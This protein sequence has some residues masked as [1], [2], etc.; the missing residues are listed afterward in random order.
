MISLTITQ[1]DLKKEITAEY[2]AS[3]FILQPGWYTLTITD[4]SQPTPKAD[5]VING[6]VSFTDTDSGTTFRVPLTYQVKEDKD[7]WRVKKTK[8]LIVRLCQVTKVQDWKQLVGKQIYAD[9]YVKES[10]R[11]T[12]EVDDLGVPIMKEFKNN[13]F[14]KGALNKII[15][16]V[17]VNGTIDAGNFSFDFEG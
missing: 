4:L 7:G 11:A 15:L 5:G 14:A 2:G 8:D 1:D 9:V 12:G 10:K 17:P 6:S 3:S 13:D 16:P